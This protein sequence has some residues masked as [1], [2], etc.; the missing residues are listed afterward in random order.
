MQSCLEKRGIDERNTE[1]VRS[2]YNKN[3]QY[4]STHSD[5]LSTGDAQGKGTGHG[6]HTHFL[7]DCNKNSTTI[8]YSN[9]DTSN[10][11]GCYD[12]NGKDGIGG[13]DWSMAVSMYNKETPYSASLVET[14]QNVS[15]GQYQV[16]YN[17]KTVRC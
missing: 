8:D 1:I 15:E 9:F 16:G 14:D 3:D 17:Q 11:G 2:D 7:P 12:I 4:S 10:G 5:A 13:R 6:G